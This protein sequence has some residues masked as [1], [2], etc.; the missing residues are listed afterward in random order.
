MLTHKE[1][2]TVS[3]NPISKWADT[4]QR[5]NYKWPISL[6]KMFTF[7]SHQRTQINTENHLPP[8]RRAVIKK[9][10]NEKC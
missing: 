7:T 3:N 1:G 4:S 2:K 8:I 9:T 10:N 6:R 5:M